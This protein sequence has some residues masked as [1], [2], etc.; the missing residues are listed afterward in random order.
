[1][2]VEQRIQ[3][4]VARADLFIVSFVP[5][6]KVI[7]TICAVGIGLYLWYRIRKWRCERGE[8]GKVHHN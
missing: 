7:L 8:T 6:L 2:S 4:A 1:M 3:I 5:I